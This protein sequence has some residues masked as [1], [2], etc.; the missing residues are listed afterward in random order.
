MSKRSKLVGLFARLD[1]VY[2]R[3]PAIACQGRCAI[4]CGP[5]P[6]SDLEARRLQLATH[7]KPR[8]VIRVVADGPPSTAI[9][10]ERCIYL[11]DEAR[12]SVYSIRP[13][14]CRAW[15][16]VRMMSCPHGCVPATWVNDVEFARLAQEVGS[17]G[18]GR[19]LRT[20]PEGLTIEPR[21]FSDLPIESS[22]RTPE[23]LERIGDRVRTLRVLHG[24][25]VFAAFTDEEIHE[26]D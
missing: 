13:L 2:A 3:L 17:L 18:G 16:L 19:L 1:A 25:R 8:T 24:G 11:K 23:Q 15:G 26:S 5:I 20:T 14:I 9:E 7:V 4:A 6:L 12:C 21:G 10:R 22:T